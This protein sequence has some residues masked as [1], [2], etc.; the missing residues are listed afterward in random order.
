VIIRRGVVDLIVAVEVEGGVVRSRRVTLH[1]TGQG[2]WRD[3][4]QRIVTNCWHSCPV[5]FVKKYTSIH[6][7]TT[8]SLKSTLEII[9]L[10]AREL[11]LM[12]ESYV[13]P[14]DFASSWGGGDK[15][16]CRGTGTALLERYDFDNL[17]K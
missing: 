1:A 4:S 14:K 2:H 12:G 16:L 11:V 15:F 7:L 10:R 13:M 3:Q 8:S 17:S 6:C 5:V 9:C